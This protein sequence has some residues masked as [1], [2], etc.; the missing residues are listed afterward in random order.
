MEL[1]S[2]KVWKDN[3]WSLGG[4]EGS[5]AERLG[6]E[7]REARGIVANDGHSQSI[8][9]VSGRVAIGKWNTHLAFARTFGFDVPASAGSEILSGEVERFG[10]HICQA[11]RL[12]L[13]RQARHSPYLEGDSPTWTHSRESRAPSPVPELG[14]P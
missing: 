6:A 10:D 4:H 13:V 2:I 7:G 12:A 1:V 14:H 9:S 3:F 8:G 5:S 11:P